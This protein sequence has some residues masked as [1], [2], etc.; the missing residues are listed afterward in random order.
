[1][2]RIG[3][4]PPRLIARTRT[5]VLALAI[6][7]GLIATAAPAHAS[8]LGSSVLGELNFN[9]SGTTNWFDSA[10]GLV[11]VAGFGN[12]AGST[13]VVIADPL[14]EF[15]FESPNS[16]IAVDFTDTTMTISD[17]LVAGTNGFVMRFTNALFS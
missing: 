16:L 11:P 13:T 5:Q 14:V 3:G 4:R 9:S 17:V 15:A 7:A 10:N 8:L 12:S 1:M 6:V 2:Y